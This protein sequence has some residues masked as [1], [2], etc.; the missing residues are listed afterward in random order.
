[1]KNAEYEMKPVM[2]KYKSIKVQ[3]YKGT[4]VQ[5]YKSLKGEEATASAV[6]GEFAD[7]CVGPKGELG[8][9]LR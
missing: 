1:M 3:K 6:P 7:E 4:R 5:R 2:N 8:S 9:M